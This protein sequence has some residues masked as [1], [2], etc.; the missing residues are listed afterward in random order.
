[1]ISSFNAN[2]SANKDEILIR[3]TNKILFKTVVSHFKMGNITN[4]EIS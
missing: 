3:L 1:M 4:T 2:L